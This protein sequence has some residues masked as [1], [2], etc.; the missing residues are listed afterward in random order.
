[1]DF[2]F[3]LYSMSF[4]ILILNLEILEVIWQ[5]VLLYKRKHYS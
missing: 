4:S 1:M 3:I 5:L 2:K